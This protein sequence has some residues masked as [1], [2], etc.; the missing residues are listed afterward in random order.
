MVQGPKQTALVM[1]SALAAIAVV[2]WL[3]YITGVEVASV[4]FYIVPIVLVAW[5][6]DRRWVVLTSLLASLTWTAV[7]FYS[8][9]FDHPAVGIWNEA[10][11][12]AIFVLVGIA[13]STVR[14]EQRRLQSANK[15]ISELLEAEHRDARTDAL[16]G[17]PNRR[18]F[19]E[20]LGLE[21]ARSRRDGKP[22]CV[23]YLDLDNFKRINDKHGHAEGDAVLK[24]VAE[25]LRRHLRASDMPGRIG[26]DEFAALLWQTEKQGAKQVGERLLNAV[27][28]IGADYPACK[29]GVSVG[30]AWF[31]RP[32]ADPEEALDDADDAMYEA[33]K[34][35]GRVNV[36]NVEREPTE[37]D[38]GREHAP[39][40]A[41]A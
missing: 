9:K 11:A 39:N 36:V 27:N 2:A 37:V 29:L 31:E 10:A 38:T 30:A 1:L 17:L 18:D 24:R 19:I 40:V 15:Q 22:L 34:E 5:T 28:E 33:K 8:R 6:L 41:K 25:A 20:G 7:E 23:L 4:M 14:R 32:P 3:D 26:G 12:L 21:I 16:T 35:K 13:I